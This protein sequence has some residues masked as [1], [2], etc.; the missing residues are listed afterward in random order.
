MEVG[1]GSF[2]VLLNLLLLLEIKSQKLL[3]KVSAYL[4]MFNSDKGLP[5]LMFLSSAQK[6]AKL[7]SC[8]FGCNRP[9]AA[10]DAQLHLYF[11]GRIRT[12]KGNR[13]NP[14]EWGLRFSESVKRSIYISETVYQKKTFN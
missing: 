9:K 5:R 14:H 3:V 13:C 10:Y 12:K 8:A 1:L 2:S 11:K 6:C 4:A 7:V